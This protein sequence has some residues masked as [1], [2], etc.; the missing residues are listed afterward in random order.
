ML[1]T[2]SFAGDQANRFLDMPGMNGN[3]RERN[4]EEPFRDNGCNFK[5]V[6]FQPVQ[7]RK[8][9]RTA[10]RMVSGPSRP[11]D[12]GPGHARKIEIVPLRFLDF[13]S[14][15]ISVEIPG[16]SPAGQ[17]RFTLDRQACRQKRV[18]SD[19]NGS[20][21]GV[22]RHFS[23]PRMRTQESVVRERVLQ[24]LKWEGRR[25]DGHCPAQSLSRP[26]SLILAVYRYTVRDYENK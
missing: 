21:R 10:L 23:L 14:E 16:H 8:R 18:V 13:S 7:S 15:P 6:K 25:D 17:E 5:R 20:V 4:A 9:A 12:H 11:N 24:D 26:M 1:R 22:G 19:E 2:N 3:T